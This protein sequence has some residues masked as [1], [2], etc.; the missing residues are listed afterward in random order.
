[1]GDTSIVRPF[2]T[3]PSVYDPAILESDPRQGVEAA[4]CSAIQVEDYGKRVAVAEHE[5]FDLAGVAWSIF[6]DADKL[7]SLLEEHEA[8][9]R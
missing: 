1:M 6:V 4:L 7:K 5:G 3:A 2:G 8:L 9:T